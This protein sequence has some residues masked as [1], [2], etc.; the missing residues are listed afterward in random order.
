MLIS[1]TCPKNWHEVSPTGLAIIVRAFQDG[2]LFHVEHGGLT[3]MCIAQAFT[4]ERVHEFVRKYKGNIISIDG[5]THPTRR[6]R[7]VPDTDNA[8]LMAE[9][10]PIGRRD[11]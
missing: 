6:L 4:P 9:I 3:A 2:D 7:I 1:C 5:V 10:I 11:K 8:E